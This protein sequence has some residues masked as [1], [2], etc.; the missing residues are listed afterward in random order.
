MPEG[1]K[2][3]DLIQQNKPN[4]HEYLTKTAEDPELIPPPRASAPA[5]ADPIPLA[6]LSPTPKHDPRSSLNRSPNRTDNLS[7]PPE[8]ESEPKPASAATRSRKQSKKAIEEEE[9]RRQRHKN[10]G[11]GKGEGGSR[12]CGAKTKEKGGGKVKLK[13]KNT[14]TLEV[15]TPANP[16]SPAHAPSQVSWNLPIK[17]TAR[18]PIPAIPAA[19]VR[20]TVLCN[21]SGDNRAISWCR[22][23]ALVSG[24]VDPERETQ[25]RRRKLS[26]NR[27]NFHRSVIVNQTYSTLDAERDQV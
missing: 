8:L 3:N 16:P 23:I 7:S 11:C 17:A 12:E 21:W 4:P 27:L 13:R 1:L 26:T 22:R 14:S 15:Q 25:V 5:P 9:Q 2:A 20:L 18:A 6:T 24:V 19:F 10:G